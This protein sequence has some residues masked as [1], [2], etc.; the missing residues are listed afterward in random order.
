MTGRGVL[1]PDGAAGAPP[2]SNGELLFAAPWES[3]AFAM[4]VGRAE[5]GV[6]SWD[7]FRGRLVRR[8]DTA[9][10]GV[11]YYACWL[12]ALEDVLA[13]SGRVTGPE[14][15]RRARDL[16]HCSSGHDHPGAGDPS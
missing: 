1:L 7:A 16:A 8:I 9:G 3:R 12:A 13:A 2:P 5:A 4:A 6:L 10:P 11:P 14:E 15:T